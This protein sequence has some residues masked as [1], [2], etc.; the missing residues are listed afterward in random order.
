MTSEC[1]ALTE[2]GLHGLICLNEWFPVSATVWK[3]LG[4]VALLERSYITG[5]RFETSKAHT[6]SSLNQSS[7]LVPACRSGCNL[8]AIA[9]APCLPATTFLAM[10]ILD[11]SSETVS[12][13]TVNAF[14]FFFYKFLLGHCVCSQDLS[15]NS[16][17][18]TGQ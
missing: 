11:Q 17:T 6:R 14:F 18:K 13:P 1:G 12:K 4:G 2:N 15:S 16:V 7:T 3:G 10:M 9:P 5:G 8:S